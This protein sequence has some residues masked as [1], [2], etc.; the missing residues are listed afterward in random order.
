MTH[1]PNPQRRQPEPVIDPKTDADLDFLESQPFPAV[2]FVGL[3]AI[4]LVGLWLLAV[5]G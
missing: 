1:L 4:A 2:L 3:A 5:F